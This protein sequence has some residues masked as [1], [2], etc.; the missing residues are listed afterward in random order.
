MKRF[1]KI[2]GI[3]L[4]AILIFLIVAGRIFI[5][6]AQHGFDTFETD[7]PEL[8][9]LSGK[10][11]VLLFSKT[12]AFRHGEAIET[13]KE[14]MPSL[15]EGGGWTLLETDNGA[16]FNPGQLQEI[17]V[18]IW[19]NVT[20]RVLNDD[21]RKAFKDW[22]MHGGGFVAIHG[23]GDF[24]HRW[25]WYSDS[26]LRAHFSHHNLSTEPVPATLSL[27]SDTL[28]PGLSEGLASSLTHA[29][30]W[31]VFTDN[32][33]EQGSG[34]LYTVDESEFDPSGNI[35]FLANDKD[36]G[37]GEDH[38]VAWYHGLGSGRVF[39]TSLGHHGGAFTSENTQ[40][41]LVNAVE[42]VGRW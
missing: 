25:D 10:K 35:P 2:L 14:L 5:Y 22:L 26:V 27:E 1:F 11:T 30:E 37:M 6:K 7:P 20:G 4:L 39:Y 31:Y 42:W 33:R 13:V 40:R 12:N 29:D 8:T 16:V 36:F 28:H 34:I 18:V 24:S 19:N 9:Q 15:A 41:M 3:T 23:A 32:P 17:D 21:Q 38:P